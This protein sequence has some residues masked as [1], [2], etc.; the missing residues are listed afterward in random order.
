MGQSES[1]SREAS[2][3]ARGSDRILDDPETANMLRTFKGQFVV[4]IKHT[5]LTI[6]STIMMIPILLRCVI[7]VL[8]FMNNLRKQQLQTSAYLLSLFA[9]GR[10]EGPLRSPLHPP[11]YAFPV[12]LSAV[13]PDMAEIYTERYRQVKGRY[14]GPLR[15]PLQPPHFAFPVDLSAVPPDMAEIYTERYRQGDHVSALLV[16]PISGLVVPPIYHNHHHHQQHHF[17]PEKRSNKPTHTAQTLEIRSDN[18]ERSIKLAKV[19]LVKDCRNFIRA[20][21]YF[22]VVFYHDLFKQCPAIAQSGM[23]SSLV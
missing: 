18:F 3:G 6:M 12:D 13:P 17:L 8:H 2:I 23:F 21:P 16:P 15:S 9:K 1:R 19:H 14:E 4:N 5:I 11:H 10:Y 7:S 22:V 20:N